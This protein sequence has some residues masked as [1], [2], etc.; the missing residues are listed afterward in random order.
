MPVLITPAIESATSLIAR[1]ESSLPGIGKSTGSGSAL[2][3]TIAITGM[4]RRLA[5]ATAFFSRTTSTTNTAEGSGP[6][7]NPAMPVRLASSFSSLRRR[8][9]SSF[10]CWEKTPPLSSAVRRSCFMRRML[11]R[12]V[13]ALVSVPP[14]QRFTT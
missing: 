13:A 2:E 7:S 1:I 3:S 10:L 11:L 8:F 9:A 12:I 4:R 5:S 6:P 14:S